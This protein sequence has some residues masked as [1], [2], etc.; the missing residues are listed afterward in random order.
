MKPIYLNV[1]LEI[2]ALLDSIVF[3]MAASNCDLAFAI[4][5]KKGTEEAIKKGP[6]SLNFL[7]RNL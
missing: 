7:I 1:S 4:L 6:M 3:N 2:Q 5:Q